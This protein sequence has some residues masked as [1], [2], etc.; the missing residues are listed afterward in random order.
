M[1]WYIKVLKNYIEFNGRARRTEYW[2][3]FLFNI[4]FSMAAGLLD[5]I[6]GTTNI[7]LT[8][9]LFSGLYTL[10]VFLPSLAVSVRRLHDI[11]KSGWFFL[12]LIIPMFIFAILAALMATNKDLMVPFV[13]FAFTVFGIAIW[14]LIMFCTDSEV[15]DNKWGPNPKTGEQSYGNS[16]TLDGDLKI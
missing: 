12:L 8:Y 5:Y 4:L 3:F 2:M 7:V 9:G 11:G 15:N 14:F 1:K 13:I 6:F 10:A 16:G